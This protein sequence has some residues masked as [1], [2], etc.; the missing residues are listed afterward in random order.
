MLKPKELVE[1]CTKKDIEGMY[2][3]HIAVRDY[4]ETKLD[5]VKQDIDIL[6]NVLK[7]LKMDGDSVETDGTSETQP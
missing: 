7:V 1:E 3:E 5:E 4:L 6:V 2:D